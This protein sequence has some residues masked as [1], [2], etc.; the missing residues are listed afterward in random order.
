MAGVVHQA[1]IFVTV[2]VSIAYVH[3]IDAPFERWRQ[4]RV[5]AVPARRAVSTTRLASHTSA[6]I[7]PQ[8]L[9]PLRAINPG[10]PLG[11]AEKSAAGEGMGS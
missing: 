2:V 10:L 11:L 8:V 6:R 4:R 5:D 9:R 7:A 3:L 1:Q